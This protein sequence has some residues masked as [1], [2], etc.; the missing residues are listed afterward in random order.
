MPPAA[1]DPD[2]AELPVT[3]TSDRVSVPW[4]MIPPAPKPSGTEYEPSATVRPEMVAVTPPWTSK[5][6][7]VPPPLTVTL[8]APGPWMSTPVATSSGPLVSVM[9]P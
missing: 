4:L 9:V 3:T 6:S 7:D 5:T 2:G 8:S 1:E